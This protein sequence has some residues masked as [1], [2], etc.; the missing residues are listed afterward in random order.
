M[1]IKK[2]GLIKL[3]TYKLMKL[4]DNIYNRAK[5]QNLEND[6]E[7]SLYDF[8]INYSDADYEEEDWL[9]MP[10]HK[11]IYKKDCY[12]Y[13]NKKHSRYL[14]NQAC[15]TT[16]EKSSYKWNKVTCKNCLRKKRTD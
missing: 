14:C 16:K 9:T 13:D 2:R 12:P 5:Y 6:E 10:I 4:I 11:I 1:K 15:N 8:L 3:D 7:K